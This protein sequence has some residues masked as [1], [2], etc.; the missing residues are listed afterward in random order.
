MVRPAFEGDLD[1][2]DVWLAV[3][4]L[5]L[6][7]TLR[8]LGIMTRR[9]Y[10]GV[11]GERVMA[12]LRN[13]VAERDGAH[14]R[15]VAVDAELHLNRARAIH[16]LPAINPTGTDLLREILTEKYIA[17]Q[18]IRFGERLRIERAVDPRSLDVL[19]PSMLLQPLIENAV[20]HGV[21]AKPAG[22]TS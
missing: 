22:P 10:S 3:G 21:G 4:A 15:H 14:L 20:T 7:G 11:S 13:R 19:V 16:G 1:R 9:Y 6:F 8:A 18:R 5:M 17:I 12:T 2:R